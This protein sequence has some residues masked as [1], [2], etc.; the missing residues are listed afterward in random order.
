MLATRKINNNVVV[1]TDDDGTEL[2][3][4]GKGIGFGQIPREIPLSEIERT[5]YDVKPRLAEMMTTVSPE[6]TEIALRVTKIAQNRLPYRIAPNAVFTIADHIQFAVDRMAEGLRVYM[7]LAYDVE[8][9]YPEEY[10]IGRYAVK[11]VHDRLGLSLPASEAVGVAMNLVNAKVCG[12]DVSDAQREA[13]ERDL[14]N[15]ALLERFTQMIEEEY[16]TIVDRSSFAY[17]RYATHVLYLLKR[18]ADGKT[19]DEKI[20][21]GFGEFIEAHP[22]EL[23]CARRIEGEISQRHGRKLSDGELFYLVLHVARLCSK[24]GLEEGSNHE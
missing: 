8:Q 3:A 23:S 4:M 17:S 19:L 24:E 1:C 7:P 18:V 12:P 22:R 6:V 10:R 9:N 11:L 21:V 20:S 16:E 13:E 15:Q 5:F 14:E 2:V